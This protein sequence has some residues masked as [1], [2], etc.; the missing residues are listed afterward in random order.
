[1]FGSRARPEYSP[2][3][4]RRA[5]ALGCRAHTGWAALVVVAGGVARPEVVIRGRAELHDPSGRVRSNAYHAARALEPAAAAALVEAAH[6]IAAEQA[7]SALE[8]T[9]REARDEGA[10]VRSCAVVVGTF[11]GAARLESILASHALVHAAEGRLYQSAL[12]EGAKSRGLDTLAIA[13]R[14]IWE[15][16]EAAVGV[17]GDELRH[18][19]DQLRRE[20]GPPWAQDQKLAAL[21][22]WIALA[23]SS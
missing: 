6:R 16:G 9:V 23:R 4:T 18:W 3:V 19:I 8:R 15:E 12:L 5:A 22:A 10:V 13:K 11:P 2:G 17:A 21:A 14:S 1:V 20:L 7:A